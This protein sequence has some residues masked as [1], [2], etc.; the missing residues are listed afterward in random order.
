MSDY[1]TWPDI[2]LSKHEGV[3]SLS[4]FVCFI[5][6]PFGYIQTPK[7]LDA[8]DGGSCSIFCGTLGV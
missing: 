7:I 6:E 5:E 3:I 1:H 4:L 8:S 2:N